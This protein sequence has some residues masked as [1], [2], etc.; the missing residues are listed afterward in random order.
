M[1]TA[2]TKSTQITNADL[3]TAIV[4]ND[5]RVANGSLREAIA[6]LEVAAADDNNSVYRFVRLRSN[7]R[8]SQITVFND[9]ITGGTSYDCGVYKTSRDGGAAV[10]SH[11]FAL[12]MDMSSASS[13]GTE[14][15]QYTNGIEN[16]E[17]QLWEVLALSADP[18]LFYD[19][20]L[21]GVTVGTGAG[22]LSMRV[23][24]VPGS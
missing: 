9:A 17:K 15:L 16:I 23:R 8:I 13:L 3:P 19:I 10:A 18:R 12:N 22:T 14:A 2:N 24:Y 5:A 6:T 21:T 1:A 4:F 11:A 7:D 20:C